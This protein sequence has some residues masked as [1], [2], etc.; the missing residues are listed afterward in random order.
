M[1]REAWRR[2]WETTTDPERHRDA[3]A[4]YVAAVDATDRIR[5]AWSDAGFPVIGSGGATG[6]ADVA[7]PVLRAL[8]EHEAHTQRLADDL[9]L[10]PAKNKQV[11]RPAGAVSAADR[12]AE[13]PKFTRL[14]AVQ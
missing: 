3:I 8:R 6:R 1:A 11:G 4:R 9:G 10:L 2:A 5:K 14:K 12:R 7:H 13:P